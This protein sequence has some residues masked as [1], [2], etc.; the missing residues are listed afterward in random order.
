MV[1]YK[2]KC[3]SWQDEN[4]LTPVQIDTYVIHNTVCYLH[5]NI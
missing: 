5:E 1:M 4:L 3:T 2:V